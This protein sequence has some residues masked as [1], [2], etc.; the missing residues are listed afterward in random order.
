MKKN[1]TFLIQTERLT[2]KIELNVNKTD[3][4]RA[5]S[6]LRDYILFGLLDRILKCNVQTGS[7]MEAQ[8]TY[9]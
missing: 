5:L 7:I 3:F 6:T 8:K 1:I 2:K 4:P 9:E